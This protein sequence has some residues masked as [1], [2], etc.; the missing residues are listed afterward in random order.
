MK[1]DKLSSR[2]MMLL[3]TM[4]VAVF[5]AVANQVVVRPIQRQF[6][7]LRQDAADMEPNL[8]KAKQ[9]VCEGPHVESDYQSHA[10][11]LPKLPEG[12]KANDVIMKAV[13]R[14]ASLHK[15]SILRRKPQPLDDDEDHWDTHIV[16]IE[17]SGKT[18]DVMQF[19]YKLRTSNELLRIRKIEL[20]VESRDK[21][22][23]TAVVR[24]VLLVAKVVE[25]KVEA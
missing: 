25:K 23:G 15:V 22:R 9:M 10:Q 2:E 6:W 21:D 18:K 14:L 5:F 1:L 8:L 24:G 20:N 7:R 11:R 16:R 12:T 4:A 19:L 17:L 3:G 13:D